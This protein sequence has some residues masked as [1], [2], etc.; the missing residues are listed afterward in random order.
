MDKDKTISKIYFEPA[1]YGSIKTTYEDAKKV[2]NK[3][4]LKMFRTG[5]KITLK[6]RNN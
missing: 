3:I 5:L 6:E 4:T 1:G 2:D